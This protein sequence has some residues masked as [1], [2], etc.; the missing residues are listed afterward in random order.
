MASLLLAFLGRIKHNNEQ[1]GYI[2]GYASQD[3]SSIDTRRTHVDATG[4]GVGYCNDEVLFVPH[5]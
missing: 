5:L 1:G 4:N 3:D 2:L